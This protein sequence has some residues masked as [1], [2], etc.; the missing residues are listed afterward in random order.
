MPLTIKNLKTTVR[1]KSQKRESPLHEPAGP[2]RPSLEFAMP[3]PEIVSEGQPDPA[4]TATLGRGAASH[5][6]PI[7]A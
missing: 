7:S 5:R 6:G 1:L 3:I 2:Q 4:K